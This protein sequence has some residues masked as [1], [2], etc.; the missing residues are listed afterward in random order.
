M[1]FRINYALYEELEAEDT[2]RTRDVYRYDIAFAD[3]NI[4]AFPFSR[5]CLLIY[6]LHC[7][8]LLLSLNNGPMDVLT[9]FMHMISC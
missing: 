1:W 2:E 7:Y 9:S 5:Y 6:C 3:F 8:I 4:L